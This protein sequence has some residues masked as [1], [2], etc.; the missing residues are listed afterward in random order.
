M[1]YHIKAS[2]R[3][4]DFIMTYEN[5]FKDISN[6]CKANYKAKYDKA[7]KILTTIADAALFC[8]MENIPLRGH[9]DS[10][11]IEIFANK[12]QGCFKY[13]Y[14][15]AFDLIALKNFQKFIYLILKIQT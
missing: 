1:N 13:F 11:K 5:P 7:L 3:A 12:S 15:L 6:I 14:I 2:Q 4:N 8:A 9:R 10:G